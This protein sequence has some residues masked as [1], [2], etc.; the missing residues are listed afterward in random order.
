MVSC[1]AAH[2]F[3]LSRARVRVINLP[4]AQMAAT[5]GLTGVLSDLSKVRRK[6]PDQKK[7]K[8]SSK[9]NKSKVID[10][11]G[12]PTSTAIESAP[13][14]LKSFTTSH[15]FVSSRF[16][17]YQPKLHPPTCAAGPCF[18]LTMGSSCKHTCSDT[19][20]PLMMTL[21]KYEKQLFS[22][23][24]LS[25]LPALPPRALARR[26]MSIPRWPAKKM[27]APPP[28][29]LPVAHPQH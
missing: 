5:G 15:R 27:P 1:R 29:G 12:L 26:P 3:Y 19:S 6:R 17:R 25:C 14:H 23:S 13:S 7:G 8:S 22:N 2:S 21:L 11:S 9:G 18:H 4:T 10:F 24:M 28:R 16:W 20:T